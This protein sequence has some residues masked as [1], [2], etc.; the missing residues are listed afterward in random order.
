MV[1][2]TK[3]KIIVFYETELGSKE[4]LLQWYNIV[5]LCDWKSFHDIKQT[6][7]SVDSVGND[8][9]VFNVS[10]NRY[11]VVAMI[12]FNRRTVYLRFVGTHKQYDKIDCKTI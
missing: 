3:A 7:N 10:G 5:S 8:R 6:F 12:H 9:Y 1:I 11:R 2:I 4:P